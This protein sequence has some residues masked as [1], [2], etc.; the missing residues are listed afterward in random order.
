MYDVKWRY[1]MNSIEALYVYTTVVEGEEKVAVG[2]DG[3]PFIYLTM[4][5]LI[6]NR[7]PEKMQIWANTVG[8]KVALKMFVPIKTM[9]IIEPMPTG[10]IQ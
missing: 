1:G 8:I 4:K 10:A 5:G 2:A 6:E 9:D 3:V 7:T